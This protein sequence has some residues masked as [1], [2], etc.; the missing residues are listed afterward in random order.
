MT[1][2]DVLTSMDS[3]WRASSDLAPPDGMEHPQA[4]LNHVFV[5]RHCQ[6]G[7]GYATIVS[8]ALRAA[9]AAGNGWRRVWGLAALAAMEWMV[10]ALHCREEDERN[11]FWRVLLCRLVRGRLLC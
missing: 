1:V 3:S 2:I 5:A 7:R 11:A 8:D 10:F 9:C 6:G 4:A